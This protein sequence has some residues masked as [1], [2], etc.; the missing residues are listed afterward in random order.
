VRT[1]LGFRESAH[2]AGLVAA[3]ASV[4]L[5]FVA[6]TAVVERSACRIDR[7]LVELQTHSLPG[8][9]HLANVRS[10]LRRLTREIDELAWSS[11]G[12]AS[13]NVRDRIARLRSELVAEVESYGAT[14]PLPGERELLDARLRP[15]LQRLD[16]NLVVLA[17]FDRAPQ[18]GALRAS[19]QSTIAEAN[20]LDEAV[21][22]LSDL[23]HRRVNTSAARILGMRRRWG[24]LSLGLDIACSLVALVATWLAVRAS[25]RF[26]WFT[27][28]NTDLLAARAE[29]LEIFAERVAHDLLN[30][31]SAVAFGLGTLALRHPD[32][33]TTAVVQRANRALERSRT[34]VHGILA[35]ARAGA[36]PRPDA[37]SLLGGGIRAA[38]DEILGS[39]PTCPPSVVVEPFPE[40]EV[41]C[42][43]AVLGV[44]LG[45]LLSNAC[46]YT[47]E[48]PVRRIVIRARVGTERVRVEVADTGPGLAPGLEGS[49]FEPYVRGPGVTQPGLGLGLATV[50]RLVESHGGSVGA[51]RAATGAVFWFEL[52]RTHPTTQ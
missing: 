47:R 39:E 26:A 20:R 24:Q 52:A 41:A 9:Q 11:D 40:C 36:C 10:D 27:T 44:I 42:D 32:A 37:R 8:A 31:M 34:M 16:A 19:A 15:S 2:L 18:D 17:A 4:A 25:R 35:F 3:F 14:R 48:L 50:K 49:I 22:E 38:V 21:S 13:P 30:P 43:E 28:R 29:E 6:A 1:I 45:N 5:A 33:E 12:L 46:K 7:E 23:S 51:R